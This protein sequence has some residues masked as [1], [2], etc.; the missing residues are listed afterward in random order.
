MIKASELTKL[1]YSIGE[2]AKMFDVN[3]SLIRFWEKEF[4]SIQPKKNK[5]G[6][7]LFSPSSILE[8]QKIYQL[9][10]IDGHTLDGAKKALKGGDVELRVKENDFDK[11]DLIQ[12]LEQIKRKLISLK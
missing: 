7:R 11:E 6:N 2:V 8:L 10:K 9:V 1:Y 4:P 3:T 5:K 12:R